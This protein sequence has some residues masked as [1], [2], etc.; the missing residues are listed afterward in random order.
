LGAKNLESAVKFIEVG[1]SYG[2]KD[3]ICT[4]TTEVGRGS[5]VGLLG[6]NGSGKS[7]FLKLCA[8]L[9]RPT[10][11][12]VL[13]LGEKI[14]P[15]LKERIAFVPEI[16]HMYQDMTAWEMIDFT[17][18]FF[19]DFDLKKARQLIEFC[20]IR[21]TAR[22]K[23]MSN[24][25]RARTKLILAMARKADL[26]LLDEPLG[27][28][29]MISREKIIKAIISTFREEEQTIIMSTHEIKEVEGIF[30]KIIM[31]QGGQIVIQGDLDDICTQ[32]NQTLSQ[33]YQ[34]LYK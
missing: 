9:L 19:T 30:D 26:V 5:I 2:S 31:L 14:T 18:K 8:G 22:I 10:K 23:D 16:D 34:N 3:G 21:M 32:R 28:I 17:S 4:I 11:G 1:K 29:D 20:D 12:E 15:Q 7:T 13:V 33:I 27:G 6:P 25:Q 24:G